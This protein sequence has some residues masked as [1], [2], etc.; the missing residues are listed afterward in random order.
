MPSDNQEANNEIPLMNEI[1]A[2]SK[3]MNGC[4]KVFCRG[5]VS[6]ETAAMAGLTASAQPLGWMRTERLS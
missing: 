2:N 1:T 3:I 6:T 5:E 4:G